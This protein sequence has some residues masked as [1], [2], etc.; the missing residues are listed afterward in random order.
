MRS[1]L[2]NV[3]I[4]SLNVDWY[5]LI[6]FIRNTTQESGIVDSR[7]VSLMYIFEVNWKLIRLK[8]HT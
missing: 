7:P 8:I 1:V 3:Q 6:N 4:H 2:F 5:Q